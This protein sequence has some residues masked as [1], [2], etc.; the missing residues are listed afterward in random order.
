MSI[1]P[2]KK[3]ALNHDI[4][5]AN[6]FSYIRDLFHTSDPVF[7]FEEEGN[8][9]KVR[10]ES[11]WSLADWQ[12]LAEAGHVEFQWQSSDHPILSLHRADLPPLP[13]VPKDLQGWVSQTEEFGSLPKLVAIQQKMVPFAANP[14]R[15]TAYREFHMRVHDRPV[16]EVQDLSIPKMLNNW[17]EIT[18]ENDTVKVEV[19][20]EGI[21]RFQDDDLRQ[22]LLTAYERVHGE[23]FQQHAQASLVNQLFDA[24]HAAHYE[25]KA[26]AEQRLFLSFGLLAGKMGEE[27]YRNFL[28]HIPLRLE[29]K[30]QEL[31]LFPDTFSQTIQ[32]EQAFTHLLEQVFPRES[33]FQIDQRR[34]HALSVV[35]QFH[36]EP[37]EFNLDAGYLRHSYYDTGMK[38]L[39]IFPEVED[40]FFADKDLNWKYEATPPKNGL[41]F[42][43]SPIVHTRAV[44]SHEHIAK[45]ASRIIE[46]INELSS[47]GESDRIPDFFKKLFSLRRPEHKL[48]IAYKTEN[49]SHL[50]T[51][52]SSEP[53]PDRLLFPLPSN[54]EQR[55]IAEQLHKQDAVTV[56]GP[57]GTGKSHTIANLT[58]HYVA[59]GKSV[60]IVSRYA[61]ALEVIRDKLP[62]GIRN[63]AVSFN[64]HDPQQDAL[65]HA[66][67][68]IKENLSRTIDPEEI[69]DL[70]QE[71]NQ[72]ETQYRELLRSIQQWMDSHQETISLSHPEVGELTLTVA[73]W[74]K[75]HFQADYQPVALFDEIDPSENMEE[76]ANEFEQWTSQ[77]AHL[78]LKLLDYQ[79]P[80]SEA[81][82]D[83]Q[84]VAAAISGLEKLEAQI[85]PVDYQSF[86]IPQL[87][88]II[89]EQVYRSVEDRKWLE[90]QTRWMLLDSFDET[91]LASLL[92][93]LERICAGWENEQKALLPYSFYLDP[94]DGTAWE[95]WQQEGRKLWDKL[96][97]GM[98]LLQKKMLSK[99]QKALMNCMVN[100]R[101][102]ETPDQLGLVIRA[103]DQ[104]LRRK[105][106]HIALN[107]YLA[108][109]GTTIS[110]DDVEPWRRKLVI[111][112]TKYR[113]LNLYQQELATAG[114]PIG[115]L[116]GAGAEDAW[117][118]LTGVPVYLRLLTQTA[119][120]EQL[121]NGNPAFSDLH[122]TA[123]VG[124]N[125]LKTRDSEGYHSAMKSYTSAREKMLVAQQWKTEEETWKNRLPNTTAA[126]LAE[127]RAIPA[128]AI[129][130][131]VFHT[132]VKSEIEQ[133]LQASEKSQSAMQRLTGLQQEIESRIAD[134]ITLKTWQRKQQEVSDEQKSALSAWRNDLINIGK[135]YGKNTQRNMASA[136]TNMQL[137]KGAVPIWIM[138][139]DTAITFFPEVD[140]GAFDLLI[141][142]EAS[143]CDISML[144]LIFRSKKC[145][146][147][148]DENQT[149]VATQASLFPIDRTNQ[150]LDR[151]LVSHPFKQQFNINNRTA[152]IY[153]LSGVIYPN[154]VTLREH[155]R[156][157]PELIGFSNKYVYDEQ[158]VPLRTATDNRFGSP[159]E[160][161]HVD[162]DPTDRRRPQ[163][164]RQAVQ[165]I[166]D[167]VEDYEQKQLE[168][169]PTV[170]ILTLD[171]SYEEHREYMIRELSRHPRIKEYSDEL[172]LLV[173]TSR[174]FQGDERDVMILTSTASHKYTESGEI[175]PPRAVLG[176]EMM[177]IYNVAISRARDK[178]I[179][180][181]SAHPEA[182]L[183]MKDTCYRRRMIDYCAGGGL[184]GPERL[185]SPQEIIDRSR[186]LY[187]DWGVQIARL[188]LEN[189]PGAELKVNFRVG[190][191]KMDFALIA[192][193]KKLGILLDGH[194]ERDETQSLQALDTQLTLTRAGWNCFRVPLTDWVVSEEEMKEKLLQF[195]E[196]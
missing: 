6:L 102:V 43:F 21:E 40:K 107:N 66:I 154:I 52:I 120:Y 128:T 56:M 20:K 167:L 139:Q 75:E 79:W 58:S 135:G 153:T 191:Y 37:H 42:S 68:A 130:A 170:G 175:K 88:R 99:P 160:A 164:V 106:W 26:H 189:Y 29:I 98:N 142:D 137:A 70:E 122:E 184:M 141:V 85:Q 13:P 195:V 72:M 132:R 115:S 157:R 118:W 105:Q 148:G 181:Y 188:L 173:G 116:T 51:E 60:L 149:S 28:F 134:L 73:D 16:A 65:K 55:A 180:L 196:S 32:C 172:N 36:Q 30:K 31:S 111:A 46:K 162:D 89:E 144:N 8:I 92:Q 147:V 90:A 96:N 103:I 131:D 179:L 41:R 169:L 64:Q 77:A 108:L 3:P 9:K 129:L 140:P 82:P 174:E 161:H 94:L 190:P 166:A 146:I 80:E 48:R 17:V 10:N 33:E 143:Q 101:T 18:T 193:G 145:I 186:S 165:L 27:T 59:Q 110:A 119:D 14:K 44:E 86:E 109:I 125:C 5:L 1:S 84:I 183:K 100:G 22:E 192:E 121:A 24:L 62:G 163:L 23:H 61:K 150:L 63:L 67:D 114:L 124:M 104:Q 194:Q 11:W 78:D 49:K 95:D 53:L 123:E 126:F 159:L 83:P 152:S 91:T 156:C 2:A 151:Y 87:E 178:A 136:V 35:D 168:E 74:A 7:R 171:S 155:F 138:Q 81:F 25:L 176:E 71:L 185:N 93:Q 19:A 47:L 97:Q 117:K 127:G 4:P 50:N 112:L 54:K 158:I 12:T 39:E 133:R 177:R 76:L 182:V 38:L 15:M 113:T 45:D 69:Q 187:G 34:Q 57:P